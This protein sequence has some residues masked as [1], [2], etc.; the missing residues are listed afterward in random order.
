MGICSV[1][2]V[3][4][5]LRLH[6]SSIFM[7][8]LPAAD[9]REAIAMYFQAARR[10]CMTELFLDIIEDEMQHYVMTMHHIS[11]LD[12]VQA[13][14]LREEGLNELTMS[15]MMKKMRAQWMQKS[16]MSEP[17]DV[18]VSPLDDEELE[19]V[20]YLTKVLVSEFHAINKYQCYMEKSEII[21]NKHLFCHL[22]NEEKEHVAELTKAIFEITQ[23]PLPPETD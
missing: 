3:T 6:P 21:H 18:V 22:M 15:G 16:A 14:M 4:N 23:E 11:M 12:P 1:S 8:A 5:A 7:S 20:C 2:V 10:T 17:E 19:A 9:E 13:D